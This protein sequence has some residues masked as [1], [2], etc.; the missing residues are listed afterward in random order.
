M[1]SESATLGSAEF[2]VLF[3]I[4]SHSCTMDAARVPLNYKYGYCQGF[5]FLWPRSH[6]LGRGN[7]P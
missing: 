1:F 3:H 4:G 2:E 5:G 6:H 7:C